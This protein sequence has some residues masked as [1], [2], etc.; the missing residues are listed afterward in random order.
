MPRS[1]PSL[2]F[3]LPP[4]SSVVDL[5]VIGVTLVSIGPPEWALL[6]QHLQQV[7]EL[8]FHTFLVGF[9]GAWL[10]FSGLESISQLSPCVRRSGPRPATAR[11]DDR[12]R[13]AETAYRDETAIGVLWW[14]LTI[15]LGKCL[16]LLRTAQHNEFALSLEPGRGER[17]CDEVA[18]ML[19]TDDVQPCP[20][21]NST[22]RQ[23]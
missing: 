1:A 22:F 15:R 16:A 23:G 2:R 6:T 3:S 5:V 17:V 19:N 18:A 7:E 4:R 9:A 12:P 13:A 20:C 8:S 11:V 10:A 21:A 14:A